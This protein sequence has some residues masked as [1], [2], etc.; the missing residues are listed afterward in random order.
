MAEKILVL[1]AHSALGA[2]LVETLAERRPDLPVI[3]ATTTERLGPGLDLVDEA[4]LRGA[5]LVLL[6]A[7]DP[8]LA[9]LA[10]AAQ[11]LGR[12]VVDL[13]GQLEVG[14]RLWPVQD[15]KCGASLKP[16]EAVAVEGGLA[17]P[18][19]AALSALAPFGLQAA[20]ITTLESA[21]RWDREGMDELSAQ[22][23]GVFSGQEGPV[24]RFGAT[25][26]FDCIPSLAEAGDDPL[27]ADAQL[28]EALADG[29]GPARPDLQLTR[30][31]VPSFSAE[32]AVVEAQLSGLTPAEAQAGAP[33]AAPPLEAMRDQLSEARGLRL[34]EAPV[35]PA[36]DAVGR[37]DA[38]VA[39]LRARPQGLSLWLCADRITAGGASLGAL[40]AESWAEAQG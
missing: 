18:L 1:G 26:A 24:E 37:S 34:V 9:K 7:A 11:Q 27:G 20:Q 2:Q 23:R 28:V 15:P 19:V 3:P 33:P 39:R 5:G 22:V 40:V 4:A 10:G 38:L 14:R 35:V 12:P 31:L 36:L 21:A 32:A 30:V 17:S 6:T 13:S 8:L 16:G 25:L 29:L